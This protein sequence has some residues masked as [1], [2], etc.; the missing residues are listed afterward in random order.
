[1]DVNQPSHLL[2]EDEKNGKS[3]PLSKKKGGLKQKKG[4]LKQKK[5]AVGQVRYLCVFVEA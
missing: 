3:W 1:M 5:F 2:L 4:G